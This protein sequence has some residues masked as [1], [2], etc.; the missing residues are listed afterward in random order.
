MT[1]VKQNPAFFN[2]P[3][4]GTT[5]PK[6]PNNP[7]YPQLLPDPVVNVT[8]YGHGLSVIKELKRFRLNTVYYAKKSE[9]RVTASPLVPVV[10]AYSVMIME[11]SLQPE[12]SYDITI[13]RPDSPEFNQWLDSCNQSMP[14]GGTQPRKY[15]WF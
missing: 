2:W 15:G 6:K 14:G 9:L 7:S 8:V 13:H 3:F 11:H 1:A 12:I 10:P 4:T 5:T